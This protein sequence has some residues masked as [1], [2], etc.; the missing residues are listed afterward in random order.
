MTDV[1]GIVGIVGTFCKRQVVDGIQQVGFTT[2]VFAQQADNI[3]FKRKGNLRMAF[4]IVEPQILKEH[5]QEL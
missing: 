4:K 2:S 3:I 5:G 1:L